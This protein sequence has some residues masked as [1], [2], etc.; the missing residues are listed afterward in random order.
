MQKF[1]ITERTFGGNTMTIGKVN[2]VTAQFISQKMKDND[3][4]INYNN[5]ATID[6]KKYF[7]LR[8]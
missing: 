5:F 1:K 2:F 3:A 6:G 8:K 4:K 7:E